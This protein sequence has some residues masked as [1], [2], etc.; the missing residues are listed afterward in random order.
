MNCSRAAVDGVDRAS[1]ASKGLFD[2][3]RD[4]LRDDRR[5]EG[6]MVGIAQD[7]LQRVLAGWQ[8]DAGFRLPRAKMHMGLVRR[9]RLVGIERLIDVDEQ[10]MVAGVRIAVACM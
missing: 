9:Y 1:P 5:G 2:R 7:Q 10:V 3:D 6:I 8:L 4:L